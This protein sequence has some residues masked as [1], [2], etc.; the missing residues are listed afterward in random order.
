MEYVRAGALLLPEEENR[1]L[2][3]SQDLL[4]PIGSKQGTGRLLFCDNHNQ[5]TKAGYKPALLE[6]KRKTLTPALSHK[7]E[8]EEEGIRNKE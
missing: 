1:F 6:E 2:E 5:H 7:W 8:R 3:I 4:C